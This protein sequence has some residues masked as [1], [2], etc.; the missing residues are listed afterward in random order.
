MLST[1]GSDIDDMVATE[2]FAIFKVFLVAL[3]V[4]VVL[5]F[6]LAG[7]IAEPVRRLATSA[8]HVRHRIKSRIEIPDFSKR[9]DEIGHLSVAIRDMT[10]ALYSRSDASESFA[11]DV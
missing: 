5:S 2:R 4:M 8:E 3:G 6:L 9:R 1:Q 10:R 7:T 11:A